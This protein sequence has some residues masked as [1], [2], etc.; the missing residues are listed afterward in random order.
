MR[1]AGRD[2]LRYRNSSSTIKPQYALQRLYDATKGRDAYFTTEVGQHQMWAAQFLKFEEPNR[3]MTSGGLGTMGYGFPAA[4]GVQVAHP[5]SLVIDIAGEA[6]LLMTIQELSTMVQ[7]RLP[8]KT[9]LLNNEYMG[10]VRQWQEF[11]HGGRYAESYMDSL[12]DFVKLAE[13]FGATGLRAERPEEVDEVIEAMIET[14]GPVIA[15]ILVDKEENVYP[16]I[17]AGAAHY[18][19]KLGPEHGELEERSEDGMVLV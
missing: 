4:M 15:D 3:W 19:M 1:G 7:Y 10:M 6:S 2:C 5:D 17:P 16:M 13:S 18:E 8:V 9:F 14:P 11:F 12:P